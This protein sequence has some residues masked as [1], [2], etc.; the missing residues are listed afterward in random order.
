[1]HES[2]HRGLAEGSHRYLFTLLG[3]EADN[4]V[5]RAEVQPKELF[6]LVDNAKEVSRQILP[7]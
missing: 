1:M 7:I 5:P 3:L 4:L 2:V 6:N